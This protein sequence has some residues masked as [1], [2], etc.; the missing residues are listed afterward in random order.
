MN[1]P[2]NASQRKRVLTA[3]IA[4]FALAATAWPLYWGFDAR[5]HET[6]DDA[7]VAGN[8]LRITPRISGTVVAVLADDTDFV[9]PGQ[10]LV[11]FD[12]ADA[13]VNLARAEA[14]LAD[15]VRRVRQG[16]LAV[17]QG[18]ANVAVREQT[19]AQAEAD[20]SR[21]TAAAADHSVSQEEYDHAQAALHRAQAELKLA[22]AQLASARAA[23]AGTAIDSHPAVRQAAARLREAY[24]AL[25]RC[26][27]R[28]PGS[29][30]VAK[31]GIQVGQQVT[32]GTPML[33]VLPL[34]QLWAEVNFKEDQLERVRIGQPVTLTADFYGR[35][36]TFR[37]KVLG[38]GAGTGAVFSQLPPQNASGNWI[39]IVQRLP[40]RV[41]LDPQDLVEHPLRVGLS[42]R[43]DVDTHDRSG[44]ALG[45][46][47]AA[48]SYSAPVDA[49][50]EKEADRRV[51]EIV[52]ANLAGE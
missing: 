38:V 42:L 36:V 29:G 24:L 23:V 33:A 37:G 3:I 2:A 44:K 12:D 10:V 48:G 7:Y 49:S 52:S 22:N 43:A 35:G 5:F 51:R 31:R 40:V 41:S 50:A 6:T 19:L 20:A 46:E 27:V 15:A 25:S 30:Y 21:R 34:D 16:F 18:R 28:S 1:I 8:M 11:R 45:T 47:A 4:A 14:E 17:D 13:R 32:A 26:E 9:R 39:K